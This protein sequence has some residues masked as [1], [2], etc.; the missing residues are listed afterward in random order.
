MPDRHSSAARPGRAHV[1]GSH[2]TISPDAKH[3]LRAIR[4]Q[5]DSEGIYSG[6][7]DAAATASDFP[8]E[9]ARRA[10]LELGSRGMIKLRRGPPA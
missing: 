6:S 1:I 3:M 8:I 7:D 4:D 9:R 2:S 10:L 5:V